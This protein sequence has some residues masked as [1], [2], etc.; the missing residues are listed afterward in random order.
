MRSDLFGA[1]VGCVLL[2]LL[3][4][5]GLGASFNISPVII[6]LDGKM[7]SDRI[8]V[9]NNGETEIS[10]QLSVVAWT[11]DGEGRDSYEKTSDIVVF[12]KI[13]S[14]PKGE[15]RIIRIGL[16][17]APSAAVEKAYRLYLQELPAKSEAKPGVAVSMLMKAGMPVFVDPARSEV[18]GVLESVRLNK[19]VVE[20]TLRNTGT[21]H[22]AP[23]TITVT[24]ITGTG[25]QNYSTEVI[26]WY[27][28]SGSAR[29]YAF[30]VPNDRC[31]DM[32]R[33]EVGIKAD[34]VELKGSLDVDKARCSP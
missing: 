7:R 13:L 33:I 18:R 2:C 20:V 23:S 19:G 3:P 1:V 10:L 30:P 15:E 5:S 22:F 29:S 28:L 25:R 17:K 9:T 24:G 6:T 34:T 16:K 12:P 11:Q 32:V 14:I 27:L 4:A 26:G 21:R 31:G 8:A